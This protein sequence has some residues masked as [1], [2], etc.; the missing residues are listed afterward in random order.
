MSKVIFI[1]E[2]AAV[3]ADRFSKLF[4]TFLYVA[5]NQHRYF[6]GCEWLFACSKF[7]FAVGRMWIFGRRGYFGAILCRFVFV[8]SVKEGEEYR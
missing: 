7:G 1:G 5:N 6:S 8:A 3:L 2:I 4:I